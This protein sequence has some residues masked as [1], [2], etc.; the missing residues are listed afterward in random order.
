ML[1][2]V[3]AMLLLAVLLRAHSNPYCA[4]VFGLRLCGQRYC[5]VCFQL[6]VFV[7]L[8][9]SAWLLLSVLLESFRFYVL[10]LW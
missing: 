1:H 9:C 4:A 7:A 3:L 8:F 6:C 5:C 10:Q 2:S